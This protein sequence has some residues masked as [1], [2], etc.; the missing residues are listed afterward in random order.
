MNVVDGSVIQVKLENG[1]VETIRTLGS[2][3]P[4]LLTGSTKDQCFAQEAKQKLEG[5]ILGKQVALERDRNY[6]RDNFGRLL[7]YVRLNSLDVNGWMVSSGWSF[8]DGRN[9]HK[10]GTDYHARQAEAMDYER[11]LWGHICEYNPDL[12]T[13]EVLR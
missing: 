7:R 1:E 10:R 9:A 8:V 2:E 11:G 4:L 3:A 5:L 13:I 6:H 12:D